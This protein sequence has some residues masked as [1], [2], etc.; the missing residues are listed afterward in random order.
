[1]AFIRDFFRH[2]QTL[3]VFF[4]STAIALYGYDQGM[5]SL[6][7]TNYNYLQTM[8]IREN[9]P[10]VGVVV[11]IYYVGCSVGAVLASAWADRF[12]R[13]SG[14]FACLA[15]SSLGNLIMFL[16]GIEG[17]ENKLV[18]A[19]LGTTGNGKAPLATMFLGRVIMGLGV[20]KLNSLSRSLFPLVLDK[21]FCMSCA[22]KYSSEGEEDC[23]AMRR[24]SENI[25]NRS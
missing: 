14:M 11:S 15:M 19:M 9:S 3:V 21:M 10:L 8:D 6:I 20:G 7:N 25:R 12:G 13:K 2:K 4:S 24:Q 17:W 1:M 16:S 23:A 18:D 22:C 5:M